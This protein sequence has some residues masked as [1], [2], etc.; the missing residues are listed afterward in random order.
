ML[1]QSLIAAAVAV[2]TITSSASIGFA[3]A[4]TPAHHRTVVHNAYTYEPA[5]APYYGPYYGPYYYGY[6]LL[7]LKHI[8]T[9]Y[10]RRRS[11]GLLGLLIDRRVLR[12]RETPRFSKQPRQ[13]RGCW[14]GRASQPSKGPRMSSRR[15]DPWARGP[16]EAV[17]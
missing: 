5:P 3:Q 9:G 11:S 15:M 12:P 6:G 17:G 14:V 8:G 2:A 16:I 10:Q 4:Q 13:A 7:R 1:C